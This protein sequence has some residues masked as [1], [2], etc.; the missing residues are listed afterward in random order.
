MDD[1]KLLEQKITM[2]QRDWIDPDSIIEKLEYIKNKKLELDDSI[3]NLKG[4]SGA[5]RDLQNLQ[6]LDQ[7]EPES[8]NDISSDVSKYY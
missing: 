3:A 6:P 7:S 4:I 1:K 5:L 8:D 2:Y